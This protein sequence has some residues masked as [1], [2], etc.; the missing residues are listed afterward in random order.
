VVAPGSPK[1][2]A[3]RIC[4]VLDV[5][6]RAPEG[7]RLAELSRRCH[8]SVSTVHRLLAVLTEWQGVRP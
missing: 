8:L 2:V 3:K 1:S 5:L 4:T 7:L 6:S